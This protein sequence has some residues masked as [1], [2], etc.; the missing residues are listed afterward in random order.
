MARDT[1]IDGPLT[2]HIVRVG[3]GLALEIE[4]TSAVTLSEIEAASI[5]LQRDEEHGER[6]A[7]IKFDPIGAD[8]PASGRARFIHRTRFAKDLPNGTDDSW[9][10]APAVND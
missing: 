1:N 3:N 2:C 10:D 4:N 5:F 8:L 6:R 9:E 7:M